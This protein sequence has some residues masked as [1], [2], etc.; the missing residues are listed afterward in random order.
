MALGLFGVVLV[1]TG[2]RS[3]QACSCNPASMEPNLNA[4][5]IFQGAVMKLAHDPQKMSITAT[6]RVDKVYQGTVS[7]DVEVS[8]ID[9]GSMCGF[10]FKKGETYLIYA[11][12][13]EPPFD[14]SLCSPSKRLADAAE[15]LKLLEDRAAP[16]APLPP[17]PAPVPAAPNTTPE[18]PAPNDAP[19]AAPEPVPSGGGG[20][21]GCHVGVAAADGLWLGMLA[22]I[23]A[24]R[25]RRGCR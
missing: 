9:A 21:S 13:P 7:G 3:A 24:A 1:L 15:D 18:P 19:A 12:A 11:T 20:C 8:T 25:Q 23:W 2:V 10:E 6:V 5:H 14:T 22:L 4:A 17:T 16:A